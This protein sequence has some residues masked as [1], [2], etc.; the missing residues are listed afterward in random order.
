MMGIARAQPETYRGLL[1]NDEY[2]T[3]RIKAWMG[4][5][6]E[7]ALEH[8]GKV[9]KGIAQSTYQIDKVFRIVQP[10]AGQSP[11]EQE[12]EIRINIPIY[13]DYGQA[14]GKWMDYSSAKFDVRIVSGA[15]L[16]VNRWALIEEYF[17]WFQS[18]LIDDVAMV[19]ETDIRGKKQLL[20]RKSLYSQL[21]SQVQQMEEAMKD[22]DG[23]IETLERQLVQ[24][25]I[26]DKVRTGSMESEKSV[27]DTQA[28]QKLLRNLMKGDYDTARK[29]LQMDMKE[30]ARDVKET[31][32]GR[33]P[34]VKE[35]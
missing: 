1:A 27:L 8:L 4:N 14:V 33:M 15:T 34:N 2:G 22:K 12:K 13:N 11:E 10:E 29:Q 32:Q 26:K 28:Q 23:T 31:E 24:A 25:G 19:A 17:R 6:V 35:K 9:F 5:T 16:P 21:Q 18:G 20:Q 30:V 3:R 7:P